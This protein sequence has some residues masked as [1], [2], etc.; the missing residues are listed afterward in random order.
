LDH[1]GIL[2]FE[3]GSDALTRLF[4]GRVIALHFSHKKLIDTA[5]A[6]LPDFGEMI[7]HQIGWKRTP[8]QALFARPRI[9]LL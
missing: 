2:G 4:H 7:N 5:A 1:E 6:V 3:V 9:I 8:A